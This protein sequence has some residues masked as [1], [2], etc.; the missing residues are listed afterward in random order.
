[1][2]HLLT[3]IIKTLLRVRLTNIYLLY[4]TRYIWTNPSGVRPK[5]YVCSRSIGGIAGSN[6]IEGE[7]SSV[8]LFVVC[9]VWVASSATG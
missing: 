9:V 3:I 4:R 2:T 8:C 1:M 6:L 7:F 5:D